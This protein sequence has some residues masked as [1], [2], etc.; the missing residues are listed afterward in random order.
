MGKVR[1]ITG[2]LWAEFSQECPS[3]ACERPKK[4]KGAVRQGHSY[5]RNFHSFL[6][7]GLGD[8]EGLSKGRWI[9][10]E[11][12][13]GLGWAQPDVLLVRKNRVNIFECKLTE[14]NTAWAQLIDLY[15]PLLRFI[16]PEE[17]LRRIQVCK[18]LRK[19]GT[20]PGVKIISEPRALHD[21]CIWNWR[22]VG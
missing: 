10:F 3:F 7:K 5:E 21:L 15:S 9:R 13:N 11:D 19:G 4:A 17:E 16:Y 14:T 1:K 18:N 2:L 12:A 22:K 8:P 20:P 6:K